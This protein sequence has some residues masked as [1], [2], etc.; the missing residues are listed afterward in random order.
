VPW[1][2]P[3]RVSKTSYLPNR[4]SIVVGDYIG[5]GVAEVMDRHKPTGTVPLSPC[6]WDLV[7]K[8]SAIPHGVLSRI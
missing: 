1:P 4:C 2:P 5:R 6:F 8:R 3:A 7:G